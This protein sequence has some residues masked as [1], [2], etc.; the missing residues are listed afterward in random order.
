K[1]LA[2]YAALV[3]IPTMIAGI[4][5]MNFEYMPELNWTLGYPLA[6][7]T[8]AAIDGYLFYRFRKAK[9]L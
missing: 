2:A 8:M 9:W 4:Y 7:G 6:V 3:A 1:R 5:G